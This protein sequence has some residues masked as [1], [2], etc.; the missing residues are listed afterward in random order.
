MKYVKYECG[1]VKNL[2][3]KCASMFSKEG[4]K[5]SHENTDQKVGLRQDDILTF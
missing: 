3:K 1:H 4:S 2:Q 5:E